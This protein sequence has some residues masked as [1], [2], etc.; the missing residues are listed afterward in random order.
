MRGFY[1]LFNDELF[2]LRDSTNITETIDFFESATSSVTNLQQKE[3]EAQ[4][5]LTNMDFN[6]D[7]NKEFFGK[8]SDKIKT[9]LIQEITLLAPRYKISVDYTLVDDKKDC[10]IDEGIATKTIEPR[11]AYLPLGLTDDNEF[12]YR[13]VKNF[14]A[15][16]EFSY[17][18]AAPYGISR[19]ESNQ[20]TLY[21]NNVKISQ[22]KSYAT[23]IVPEDSHSCDCVIEKRRGA[24]GI[25]RKDYFVT[26]YDTDA[27]QLEFK[28]MRFTFK[29]RRV[30]IKLQVVLNDYLMT[31]SRDDINSLL[32]ANVPDSENPG[33][34]EG[35]EEPFI[36]IEP[37]IDPEL[38]DDSDID[39]SGA[40]SGD[41]D[42][43][44]TET[45]QPPT[46]NEDIDDNGGTNIGGDSENSNTG[47][48]TIT[49]DETSGDTP[50][51]DPSVQSTYQRCT[52]TDT[53]ALKVVADDTADDVFD[54]ATMIKLVDVI[55][56]I[57]DITIDEYVIIV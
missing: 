42:G 15:N 50:T 39:D 4:V 34:I 25:L 29:P 35:D 13:V 54:A 46:G 7:S 14:I 24:R 28:P 8:I 18:S 1:G 6:C 23:S 51:D 5:R 49:D 40:G 21:I 47:D 30:S 22:A 17:R 2:E 20:F 9:E 26:I 33:I 55:G 38:P 16:I 43:E 56:S 36:P 31:A 27:E 57:P 48:D 44:N 11:N 19:R 52:E 10:I 41:T 3:F 37:P 53:G 12:V 32:E 45:E